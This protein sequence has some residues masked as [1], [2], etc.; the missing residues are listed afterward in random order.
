VS[1]GRVRVRWEK[2]TVREFTT[3]DGKHVKIKRRYKEDD[4]APA[5]EVEVLEGGKR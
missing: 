4:C 2:P 1:P 3:A 5:C